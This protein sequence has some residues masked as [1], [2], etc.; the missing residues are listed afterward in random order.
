MVWDLVSSVVYCDWVCV[1]M[2]VV[3]GVFGLVRLGGVGVVRGLGGGLTCEDFFT[4]L[5]D[6]ARGF[7]LGGGWDR[8][9][10][11]GLHGPLGAG[12][13]A[14]V[15]GAEAGVVRDVEV[16]AEL[17]ELVDDC[18][19][20]DARHEVQGC[21]TALVLDVDDLG[22]EVDEADGLWF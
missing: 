12:E 10:R 20:T 5:V 17:V 9:A 2:E 22:H 19:V 7:C 6:V 8:L 21:V 11:G 4:D 13:D 1:R 18:A 16:G 3:A 15:S 14:E